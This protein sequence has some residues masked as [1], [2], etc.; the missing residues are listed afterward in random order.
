MKTCTK[1]GKKKQP[2]DFYEDAK[3]PDGRASDCKECRKRTT[4]ANRA[5]KHDY[6]VAYDRKRHSLP[7]RVRGRADYAKSQKGRERLAASGRLQKRRYP[8]RYA[9]YRAVRKA[10]KTGL[11]IRRPCEVCGC[12]KVQAH[13]DDYSKPLEVRWLC[14]KHHHE[15]H[16]TARRAGRYVNEARGAY[17]DGL[18][19]EGV[20]DLAMAASA[21]AVAAAGRDGNKFWPAR[22]IPMPQGN[23]RNLLALGLAYVVAEIMRLD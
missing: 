8:E 10:V 7:K 18:P 15:H 13:H 1:C 2:S 11:L 19:A 17:P 12:E 20:V 22:D 4:K 5:A 6:Y 9:A 14:H 3:L 23:P 21:C 16:T